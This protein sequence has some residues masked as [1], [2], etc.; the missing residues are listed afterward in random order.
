MLIAAPIESLGVVQLAERLALA[1]SRRRQGVA[2][3]VTP[4]AA[5]AMRRFDAPPASSLPLRMPAHSAEPVDAEETERAAEG[6]AVNAA[7]DERGGLISGAQMLT[8][9]TLG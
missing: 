9:H 4:S 1:I 5:K 8:H 7:Q 3:E 6:C 2:G